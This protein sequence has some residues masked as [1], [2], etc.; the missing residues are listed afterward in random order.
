MAWL[1]Q[2]RALQV[3]TSETHLGAQWWVLRV[4]CGPDLGEEQQLHRS[5]KE[6]HLDL[7]PSLNCR[8]KVWSIKVKVTSTEDLRCRWHSLQWGKEQENT[9]LASLWKEQ[10]YDW[11]WGRVGNMNN[12]SPGSQEHC[13]HRAQWQQKCTLFFFFST[14]S[15]KLRSFERQFPGQ[16][17]ARRPR[18]ETLN[19]SP[20]G[21]PATEILNSPHLEQQVSLEERKTSVHWGQS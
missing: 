15:A 19:H 12:E 1:W 21:G 11:T 5:S 7:P 10:N 18:A 16:G 9:E 2:L 14:L 17:K 13:A 20:K 6:F 3:P 4:H 8:N